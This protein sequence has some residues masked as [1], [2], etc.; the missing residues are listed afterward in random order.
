MREVSQ[1]SSDSIFAPRLD[2]CNESEHYIL[3]YP[4]QSLELL[5]EMF[6]AVFSMIL[7]K[8]HLFSGRSWKGGRHTCIVCCSICILCDVTSVHYCSGSFFSL[9]I[10]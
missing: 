5:C 3:D 1:T 10:D 7:F 8:K 2:I 9:N 6:A 4:A